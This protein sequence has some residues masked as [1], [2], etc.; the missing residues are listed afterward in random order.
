MRPISMMY[1]YHQIKNRANT[2]INIEYGRY[3]YGGVI[4]FCPYL[5][6]VSAEG[7]EQHAS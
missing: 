3:A 2:A 6:T 1:D 4:G 5:E 7:F